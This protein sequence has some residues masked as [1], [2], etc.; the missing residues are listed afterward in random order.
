LEICEQRLGSTHPITLRVQKGLAKFL[1]QAIAEG[2]ADLE[3][4]PD[5]PTIQTILAEVQASLDQSE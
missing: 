1:R 3:A 2:H 5:N 4:L